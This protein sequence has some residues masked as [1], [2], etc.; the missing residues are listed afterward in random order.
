MKNFINT[1]TKSKV[2]LISSLLLLFFVF[3]FLGSGK[4]FAITNVFP[5]PRDFSQG[6]N[7]NAVVA[8]ADNVSY[9]LDAPQS[10]I[11]IYMPSTWQGT[12][13]VIIESGG[14]CDGVG[15]A[16][17]ITTEF[18]LYR[19]Q[20]DSYGGVDLAPATANLSGPNTPPQTVGCDGGS[21]VRM[22][23]VVDNL[24]ISKK[25]DYKVLQLNARAISG[26]GWNTF[27]V[28]MAGGAKITYFSS[29]NANGGD[30]FA[31]KSNPG[32]GRGNFTLRF[33]STCG[34][35]NN[36]PQS[37]RYFDADAGQA[38]QGTNPVHTVVNGSI[39]RDIFLNSPGGYQ[40]GNGGNGVGGTLDL[41]VVKG[42]DYNWVWYDINEANGIQ[43]DLPYDSIDYGTPC[44][45]PPIC[46]INGVEYY[47][48]A[49]IP[50]PWV[51]NN[52][53]NTCVKPGG[54]GG[55]PPPNVPNTCGFPEFGGQSNVSI[56]VPMGTPYNFS[57]TATNGGT[58]IW[59]NRTSRATS[60]WQIN[61]Y[62]TLNSYDPATA[63]IASFGASIP[64]IGQ[65]QTS[66]PV[67]QAVDT[68]T[69][70]PHVYNYYLM[71]H[72]FSDESPA[73]PPL[74]SFTY[75][76]GAGQPI[77]SMTVNVLA[78]NP[79]GS[80]SSV[81]CHNVN[82]NVG[83]TRS[84]PGSPAVNYRINVG[85]GS[86][87]GAGVGNISRNTFADVDKTD[88]LHLGYY[89][90]SLD[91]QDVYGNWINNVSS[92]S[93]TDVCVR[94]FR[95]NPSSSSWEYDPKTTFTFGSHVYNDAD[96]SDPRY[97]VV[98]LTN[99]PGGS[100][101]GINP[102]SNDT[103]FGFK[104]DATT[105]IVI[106]FRYNDAPISGFADQ[107]CRVVVNR[108]PYVKAFGGS[109]ISGGSFQPVCT[110]KVGGIFARMRAIGSQPGMNESGSGGQLGAFGNLV[111]GFASGDIGNGNPN[112]APGQYLSPGGLGGIAGGTTQQTLAQ[113]Y[114]TSNY[115]MPNYWDMQFEDGAKKVTMTNFG[116]N[117][118]NGNEGGADNIQVLFPSTFPAV[119]I[120]GGG[121]KSYKNHK[122]YF[123]D[124]DL[125]INGNV[126]Y[127][128]ASADPTYGNI[129]N[130]P[131]FTIVV[132]GNIYIA[133]TVS[134]LDGLYISVQRNDG[135][136][137]SIYTCAQNIVPYT[138]ASGVYTAC[139]GG[140]GDGDTSSQLVF[141]GAVIAKNLIL[142]RAVNTLANSTYKEASTATKASEVFNFAPEVYLSPPIFND[143]NG[144]GGYDS[145][146]ILP[147]IL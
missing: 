111:S 15:D 53:T 119:S 1:I 65:N 104:P 136:G 98:V 144:K 121:I 29:E 25:R 142:N 78:P 80:V 83:W 71:R 131:N 116:L 3:I 82:F 45:G 115:C 90:V 143:N 42:A 66:Q 68:S 79:T 18:K 50:A 108:Y 105:D 114:N 132:R 126:E 51:Y 61:A 46:T 2:G 137:G 70:G 62:I 58:T 31:L 59:T 124:K 60:P 7:V 17:N 87:G 24:P 28:R 13:T 125:V 129:N 73:V 38:N 77:C 95:C 84:W 128:D 30:K 146:G 93:L 140:Y 145:L 44:N 49:S 39:T 96:R 103:S 94:D 19:T 4:S 36:N 92:T 63:A 23:T 81:D 10:F 48:K 75:I 52:A 88:P 107:T 85:S 55:N 122:T 43:F 5:D 22:S 130:V 147:P 120:P 100:K 86:A 54:G 56:D 139:R 16:G 74:P 89:Y 11:R 113:N 101:A 27:K 57:V 133:P 135:S 35:I 112:P 67:G 123:I 9:L 134:R 117:Q 72:K 12:R 47:D 141:N 14:S 99:P 69:P 97:K 40:H 32:S 138:S 127:H 20:E 6:T 34:P 26:T 21:T 110:N 8:N 76:E 64:A 91:V 102:G 109:I 118:I 33:R 41:P 37:L 106:A